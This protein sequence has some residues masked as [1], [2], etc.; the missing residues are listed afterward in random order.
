[1]IKNFIWPL[2]KFIGAYVLIISLTAPVNAYNDKTHDYIFNVTYVNGDCRN[3][4]VNLP[5]DFKY[6]VSNNKG[7]YYLKFT[8][9]GKTIWGYKSLFEYEGY[10]D[11]SGVLYV[12]SITKK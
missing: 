6:G 9:E 1:M 11:I 2:I 8:S 3:I 4:I 7:S 5:D 10:S 12:N